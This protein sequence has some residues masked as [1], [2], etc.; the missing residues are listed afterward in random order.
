MR[1]NA[2]A[3]QVLLDSGA[4][5]GGL[6]AQAKKQIPLGGNPTRQ[7]ER[8]CDGKDWADGWRAVTERNALS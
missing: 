2:R 6:L 1:G 5:N 7:R 8:A 4:L 3:A